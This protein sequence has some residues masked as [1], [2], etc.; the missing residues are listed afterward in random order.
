MRHKHDEYLKSHEKMNVALSDEDMAKATGGAGED[1]PDPKFNVGDH[2]KANDGSDWEAFITGIYG[3]Y[4][5]GWY[6][7]VHAR[8]EEGWYDDIEWE[9]NMELY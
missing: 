8:D 7:N 1:A 6:Y 5:I 3:Y 4:S 2:V 9:K